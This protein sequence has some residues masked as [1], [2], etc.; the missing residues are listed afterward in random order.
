MHRVDPI[1]VDSLVSIAPGEHSLCPVREAHSK[2]TV[3]LIIK[4]VHSV[5][6]TRQMGRGPFAPSLRRP[7]LAS[8]E[9]EVDW[10]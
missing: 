2:R 5:V 6:C 7:H 8:R 3:T 9:L 10:W 1:P 4:G